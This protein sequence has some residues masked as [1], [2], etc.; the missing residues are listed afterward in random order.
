MYK[1]SIL[2]LTERAGTFG[3][4]NVPGVTKRLLFSLVVFLAALYVLCFLGESSHSGPCTRVALAALDDGCSQDDMQRALRALEGLGFFA[5]GKP[6]T[7]L[8]RSEGELGDDDLIH[9]KQFPKLRTLVLMDLRNV[10]SD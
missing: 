4:T 7:G 1:P 5:E 2:S 9:L 10:T 8:A 6:V 3:R